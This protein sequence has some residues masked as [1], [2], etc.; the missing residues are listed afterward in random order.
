M[1][2]TTNYGWTTPDNTAY[3]KDGASA[4]RTLGSSV[5]TSLFNITNGK[6]VGLA[7]ISAQSVSAASTVTFSS[8]FTST[9]TDY[10]ITWSGVSSVANAQI[11]YRNAT[12]GTPSTGSNYN[13]IE[14]YSNNSTAPSNYAGGAADRIHLFDGGTASGTGLAFIF[15]PFL[16]SPTRIQS[17]SIGFTS[18]SS[19]STIIGNGGSHTVSTSYDGF[20]LT[21]NTGTLTGDFRLYGLRTS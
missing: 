11:A 2:T 19:F 7:F 6:N 5:D 12:S 3:V 21:P 16:A 17:N 8:V 13:G 4:I 14:V 20:V 15:D 9:F 10:I 18:S 1:A